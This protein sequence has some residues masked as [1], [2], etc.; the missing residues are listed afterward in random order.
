MGRSNSD[1]I[2]NFLVNFLNFDDLLQI[3]HFILSSTGWAKS[4]FTE[5]NLNFVIRT[6]VKHTDFF[7]NDRGISKV[8]IYRKIL[9]KTLC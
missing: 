8:S 1:M 3:S 5:K 9:S 7:I 4:Q 6:C 2:K